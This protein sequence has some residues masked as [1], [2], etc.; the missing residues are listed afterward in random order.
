MNSGGTCWHQPGAADLKVVAIWIGGGEGRG[1]KEREGKG[2]E[3]KM[4]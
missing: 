1:G 3:E 4:E 2:R